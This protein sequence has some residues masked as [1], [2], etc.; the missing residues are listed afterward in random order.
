MIVSVTFRHQTESKA[1]RRRVKTDCMTLTK[2]LPTINRIKVNFY[3]ESHNK[4]SDLITCHISITASYKQHLD[5]YEHQS[6]E[7]IAFDRALQRICSKL[8]RMKSCNSM[9]PIMDSRYLHERSQ[10]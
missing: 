5:I 2:I 9:Y 6:C 10:Q 8:L 7:T 1:F 3:Y 4:I